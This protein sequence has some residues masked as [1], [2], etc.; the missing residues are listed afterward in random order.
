MILSF[1]AIN[2]DRKIIHQSCP[3]CYFSKSWW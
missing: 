1:F 2:Q 3:K